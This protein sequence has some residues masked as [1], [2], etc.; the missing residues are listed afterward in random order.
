MYRRY[1]TAVR[2]GFITGVLLTN[3]T[4]SFERVL[5]RATRGNMFLK[6]SPIEVGGLYTLNAVDAHSLEAPGFIQPLNLKCMPHLSGLY[7]G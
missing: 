3:K 7:L 1:A 4:A 2:L 5:F 6:Q